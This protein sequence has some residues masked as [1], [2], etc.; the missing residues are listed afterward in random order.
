MDSTFPA[1]GKEPAFS[2]RRLV[3]IPVIHSQAEMGSLSPAI[4]ALTVSKLGTQAWE[5]NL[6]M[7]DDIWSHI[8]QAIDG[9]SLPFAKV[10]LYQDGLPVCGRELE[11]VSDLAKTGSRNHQLL[12]RLKE[13]GATLMGTESAALLVEEYTLIKQM[14]ATGGPAASLAALPPGRSQ[15]LLRR[16]D[17]AIA[18]R[19]NQTLG[20]A[21]TG[22][23]FLG[24]L[25][26]L[27]GWL[28]PDIQVTY[29]LYPPPPA[30]G[31]G[32]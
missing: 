17:Q 28:A 10:R 4:Q 30:A 9:W 26:S 19:I 27:E 12:L 29:P 21:E 15:S 14:L 22:L 1:G 25:H 8:E 11:I 7:V 3:H 13:R 16:R 32:A 23:L 5:R 6:A 20:P 18:E 24:M 31:R 2:G